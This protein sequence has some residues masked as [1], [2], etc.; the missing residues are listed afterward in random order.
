M[1]TENNENKDDDKEVA[2]TQLIKD[3]E[4]F[5]SSIGFKTLG[6]IESP[7][8]GAKSK[9]IEYLIYLKRDDKCQA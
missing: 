3:I 6:V 1:N 9:N 4:E 8:Q 2:Y 5:C 7:I